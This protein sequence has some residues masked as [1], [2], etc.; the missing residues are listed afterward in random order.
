MIPLRGDL[1]NREVVDTDS[2]ITAA[3]CICNNTACTYNDGVDSA[4]DNSQEC[5]AQS[6]AATTA[7]SGCGKART[8]ATAAIKTA[9]LRCRRLPTRPAAAKNT[10]CAVCT[11]PV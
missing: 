2:P 1:G 4:G 9:C 11:L 10:A 3:A 5:P 6:T 8:A 7:T